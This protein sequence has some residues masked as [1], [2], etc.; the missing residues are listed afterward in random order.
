MVEQNGKKTRTKFW[1]VSSE[2]K[3]LS[4]LLGNR[5]FQCDGLGLMYYEVGELTVGVGME[6]FV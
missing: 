4:L 3:W 1:L 5:Y 2:F 6:G